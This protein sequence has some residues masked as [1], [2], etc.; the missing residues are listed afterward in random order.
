MKSLFTT[1]ENPP[2]DI[3][4]FYAKCA[5]LYTLLCRENSISNLTRITDEKEYWIKHIYDSLL[6]TECLPEITAAGSQIADLGCGA[7]FPSLVL[8]AGFPDITVTAIDSTGKKTAFVKKAAEMLN[9]ANLSVITGR[10][11]EIASTPGYQQRF[12]FITARAVSDTKKIFREVRRMLTPDGKIAL[13]K[14]PESAEKEI[15]G[16]RNLSTA[17]D[18]EWRLSGTYSLPENHGERVFIIGNRRL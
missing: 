16:I 14:T 5:D 4:L 15:C 8:A 1:L 11:R 17:G 18:F 12:S 10:G 3:D 13:F 2:D 6:L 7:G 9:L